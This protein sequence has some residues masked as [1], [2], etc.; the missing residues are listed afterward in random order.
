M[1]RL[2]ALEEAME[3][4]RDKIRELD[5]F[6]LFRKEL[7]NQREPVA[8]LEI[9]RTLEMNHVLMDPVDLHELLLE[10]DGYEKLAEEM[11]H[12]KLSYRVVEGSDKIE[13][14]LRF[15]LELRGPPSALR[16]RTPPQEATPEPTPI[17]ALPESEEEAETKCETEGCDN[18]SGWKSGPCTA[19]Y[20]RNAEGEP[21]PKRQRMN[22]EE[23]DYED[24]LSWDKEYRRN[25]GYEETENEWRLRRCVYPGCDNEGVN[26]G[27][28]DLCTE[29]EEVYDQDDRNKASLRR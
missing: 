18:P 19:C 29:R 23:D 6:T 28:C 22:P 4:I 16:I 11:E 1:W 26:G 24:L 27:Y 15:I 13:F 25:V 10:N 12:I 17:P 20:L 3:G 7:F 5:L 14:R 21:G 8:F 2:H 9:G